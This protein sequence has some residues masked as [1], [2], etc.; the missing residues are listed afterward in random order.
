VFDRIGE[1]VVIPPRHWS[2]T[3]RIYVTE[4]TMDVWYEGKR[5]MLLVGERRPG[6]KLLFE[7]RGGHTFDNLAVRRIP[8]AEIPDTSEYVN[9]VETIPPEKRVGVVDFPKLKS[10]APDQPV[11]IE[12]YPPTETE[13]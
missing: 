2:S 10:V 6:A 8:A 1:Q 3:W 12:F 4:K 13:K 9:A 5:R 11:R 7:F